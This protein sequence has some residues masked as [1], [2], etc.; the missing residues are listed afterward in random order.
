MTLLLTLRRDPRHF[1]ETCISLLFDTSRLENQSVSAVGLAALVEVPPCHDSLQL[2]ELLCEQLPELIDGFTAIH[3][4]AQRRREWACLYEVW[5]PE[6][7][8]LSS[9]R[10][11]ICLLGSPF[12][13][14]AHSGSSGFRDTSRSSFGFGSM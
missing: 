7:E 5:E 1:V 9:A 8:A 11:R 4:L 6:R 12:C 3:S 14:Q 13:I 10:Q 2:I